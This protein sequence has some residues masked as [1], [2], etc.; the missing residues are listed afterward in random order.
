M[1]VIYTSLL[2]NILDLTTLFQVK[3]DHVI[4][5]N[6]EVH[7]TW[8]QLAVLCVRQCC[9]TNPQPN[10]TGIVS[11]VT[12]RLFRQRIFVVEKQ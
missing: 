5:I 7:N 11:N 8:Q 1:T 6:C 3:W 9:K 12:L 2:I 4:V 10:E